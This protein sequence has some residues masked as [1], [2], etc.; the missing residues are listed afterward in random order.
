MSIERIE[1]RRGK[2]MFLKFFD[3]MRS[4]HMWIKTKNTFLRGLP[5]LGIMVPSTNIMGLRHNNSEYFFIFFFF[6]FYGL[7]VIFERKS[8][9]L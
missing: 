3:R 5:S 4:K 2:I 7:E 6:H 8:Y 9:T 1:Y